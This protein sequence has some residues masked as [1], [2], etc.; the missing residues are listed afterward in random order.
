VVQQD[1]EQE[2]IQQA[3]SNA[4]AAAAGV[5]EENGDVDFDDE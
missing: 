4:I 1:A 5:T 3:E 2:H